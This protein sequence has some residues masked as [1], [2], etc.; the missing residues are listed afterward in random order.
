MSADLSVWGAEVC[1]DRVRR[2]SE[3]RGQIL[4]GFVA[5]MKSEPRQ[6][7]LVR[8]V[9]DG[10]W[11]LV[12][13]TLE[14]MPMRLSTLFGEW[15]YLL[16]AALDGV[17]YHL[18][19]K[20][21]GEDPPPNAWRIYFPIKETAEQYDDP[22]HRSQLSAISSD[23]FDMLRKTQPFNTSFSVRAH[24]LWWI[25]E[26]ARLDRHRRGHVLAPHVVQSRVVAR[27]PVKLGDYHIQLN[28]P[29]PLDEVQDL[30]ILDVQAPPEFSEQHI[31]KHMEIEH[32]L[33]GFLDVACWQK[34]AAHPMDKLIFDSR[35]VALE[36][37][38]L[39][40]VAPVADG[41]AF[42]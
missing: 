24:P 39:S 28:K 41:S 34:N 3:V 19:V 12:L 18:A 33:T 23:T 25:E 17:A 20:D 37:H 1:V 11:T 30:P 4:R 31:M 5:Y 10:E 42:V 8:G 2:A 15:L 36:E 13:K 38:V 16:R 6:F 7:Q 40:I 35:M 26:L 22:K 14:P 29:L 9:V 32:A 21:S 27:A